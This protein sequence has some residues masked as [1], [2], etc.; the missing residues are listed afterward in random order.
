[1][2]DQNADRLTDRQ[3]WVEYWSQFQVQPLPKEY[4]FS[5][6]LNLFPQ[7]KL[8]NQKIRFIEI[9]GFPGNFSAYFYKQ[10]GYAVTLLD[11]IVIPEPI[12]QIEKAN[13]LPSNCIASIEGDF[14][15][16]QDQ[17]IPEKYDVVF[18]AGFIEHFQDTQKVI[19]QH[20]HFLRPEGLLYISLPNF[21]G[22]NGWVQR[23]LDPKNY[24][25][26]NIKAMDLHRLEAIA[27]D[28]KLKEVKVFYHGKPMLWLDHPDRVPYPLRKLIYLTSA[29][30]GRLPLVNWFL[31]PHIVLMAKR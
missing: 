3:F 15:S 19:L 20:L 22:L 27:R 31:S 13:Q 18:S 5:D 7:V 17:D 4:F 21:C 24:A 28:L 9:G 30:L 11:Y 1:M 23:I 6:L 25:L 16:Y 8:Q 10:M 26:H 2:S 29:V 12:R 14:F